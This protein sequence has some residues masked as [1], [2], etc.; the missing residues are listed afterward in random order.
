MRSRFHSALK[1][2]GYGVAIALGMGWGA[3]ALAAEQVAVQL[4]PVKQTVAVADLQAFVETGELSPALQP[5]QTLLTEDVRQAL[6]SG[7]QLNPEASDNLVQGLLNSS[8]GDRLIDLLTAVI[9]DS[10][11][12]KLQIAFTVGARSEQ[13][14]SL[15]SFL[16]AYPEDTITIDGTSAIALASQFN[17]PY[18]QSQA[19]SSTLDR[20]LTVD[21]L[22]IE[23]N[24][25][26]TEV[27][28]NLV[29]RQTITLRDYERDRT[30]PVD[31]FWTRRS[32]GPLIV[33]SHGYGAD[34][35]FLGYLAFHL[36]S[37]GFTVAALEH[38]GS[39]VAW[40]TEVTN[41][42]SRHGQL[43]AI[44]P[45]SEFIDRPRD[46]SFLLDQL[47]RMNR[48]STMLHGKL[49]TEQVVVIGHSLG[50]YTALALAG[51]ELNPIGLREFCA[52]VGT[53]G[54]APSDWLQCAVADLEEDRI[55]L[56]DERVKRIIALNPMIGRLFDEQSLSQIT[57]PTLML[58]GTDDGI[59]PAVSQ[60]MLPFSVLQAPK[61]LLTAIGGTHLSV[62]D[63][64]N[65]N[66][67]L[68][69]SL[70]VRERRG[71]E[72]LPLRQLLRAVSLAFVM[73]MTPEAE[74]YAPF[75]DP[76]YAQSFSTE[77]LKLRLNPEL[78]PNLVNWLRMVALPME[79]LVARTLPRRDS[80]REVGQMTLRNLLSQSP[81]VMFILP[82][83]LPLVG[84]RLLR[85]NRRSNRRKKKGDRLL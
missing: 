18:W 71:E 76:A 72:T 37:Y 10:D 11:P 63:P 68:T 46:I 3:P 35:R 14:L 38:P 42:L 17:L 84:D 80:T 47:E 2:W 5:Y 81:L 31:L 70:F 7:L 66:Q 62:G 74:Q 15:L 20:E 55:N 4:G 33:I 6:S 19:L 50:G 73:Q 60:Q 26:P 8:A 34:R 40:L 1:R 28:I 16:E 49:N 12:E 27:G 22:P 56:R 75:L 25:S 79:R 24:L 36:S 54:L 29:R 57:I 64:A 85:L 39:N 41:G 21:A 43:A 13:G 61:Y 59:V 30:I 69:R 65:L 52:E 82:G 48:Y 83:N 51:A 77:T 44:L 23:T 67:A 32:R 45:A 78:P 9:P 53:A 58:V